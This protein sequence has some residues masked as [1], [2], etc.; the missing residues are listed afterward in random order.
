R[1]L[2][3]P[4]VTEAAAVGEDVLVDV[5][6][7]RGAGDVAE[8]VGLHLLDGLLGRPTVVLHAI[9]SR[10]AAGA[11]Q[12]SAAVNQQR[13]VAIVIEQPQHLLDGSGSMRWDLAAR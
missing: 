5:V 12:A 9:N 7:G 8:A 4:A 10:H 13:V 2:D 6:V 1:P 3:R 11:V